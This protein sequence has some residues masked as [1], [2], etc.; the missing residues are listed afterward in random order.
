MKVHKLKKENLFILLILLITFVITLLL[1]FILGIHS[2]PTFS[3]KTSLI[4]NHTV[5][6]IIDGD[7]FELITGQK[8]RLI[9]INAP[10]KGEQ[11]YEESKKFLEDLILDKEIKLEK[12]VSDTDKYGRFLRYAY[13][14]ATKKKGCS[15]NPI[16]YQE[17]VF[18]NREIVQKGF[19]EVYKYGPDT[20]KCKEIKDTPV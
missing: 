14:N 11:G 4:E 13:V 5:A 20:Q 10:E 19:G 1:Y 12:D 6:R 3:F 7:T 16:Y 18:V 9:C 2:Q 8:V 15:C 17:E